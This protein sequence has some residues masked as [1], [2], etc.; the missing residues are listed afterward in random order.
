MQGRRSL[1]K[2]PVLAGSFFAYF[3]A[4][5]QVAVEDI[6]GT[7]P[8]VTVERLFQE[9]DQDLELALLNDSDRG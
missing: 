3:Q 7:M 8:T 6:F 1:P 2:D 9:R 4:C 5:T